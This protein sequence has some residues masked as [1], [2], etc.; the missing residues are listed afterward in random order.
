MSKKELLKK[1]VLV[2]IGLGAITKS[3]VE[4]AVS[5]LK[6]AGYLNVAEGKKMARE[7]LAEVGKREK[8]LKQLVEKRLKSKASKKKSS[9]KKPKKKAAKKN[10]AKKRRAVKRKTSRKSRR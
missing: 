7:V 9:K 4:G 5:R 1:S 8:A 3:K 6:K 10:L 2:A